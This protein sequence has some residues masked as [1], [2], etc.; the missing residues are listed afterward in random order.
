MKRIMALI[1]VLILLSTACAESYP[2]Y[3]WGDDGASFALLLG[4]DGTILTPVDQYAMIYPITDDGDERALF[5]AA[6]LDEDGEFDSCVLMNDRG[7]ILLDRSFQALEFRRN[8]ILATELSG[9]MTALDADG[10]VLLA[11]GSGWIE[12][13]GEGG[14]LALK[15]GESFDSDAG[16]T[17][18]V[19]A[20]DAEGEETETGVISDFWSHGWYSEG[21]C[22]T[23]DYSNSDG[24]E[25]RYLDADGNI[26]FTV[27]GYADDFEGGHLIL[28]DDQGQYHLLNAS[29]DDA[30]GKAYASLSFDSTLGDRARFIAADDRG[31]IEILN[32]ETLECESTIAPCGTKV[33]S[34]MQPE[35]GLIFV[36]YA[37]RSRIYDLAGKL[38]FEN[39]DYAT[40][41][42]NLTYMVQGDD[43]VS[44]FVRSSGAYPD[45]V[46]TL[47][48]E[49][50]NTLGEGHSYIDGLSSLKG[51]ARYLVTDY[52]VDRSDEP[53]VIDES[54]RYG[55]C[56]ETGKMVIPA[57]Y[58]SIEMLA[59]N[60]YWVNKGEKW[61]MIDESEQWLA[62]VDTDK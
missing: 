24:G 41:E 30:L 37:D 36:W 40:T 59:W 21:L 16:K 32:P 55:V 48:D 45:Q 42:V 49:S 10:N 62:T 13:N 28:F 56:D 57:E 20:V 31:A 23:N 4:A 52:E 33:W 44:R 61:G 35:N 58:D 51:A 46:Q 60:H 18:P 29:G 54:V 3:V 19:V 17:Y 5:C 34:A 50:G 15:T 47:I 27:S 9:C 11:G 53:V 1:A 25:T 2:A 12:P 39:L 26:A 43:S 6:I 14:Y 38:L 22:R 8:T 7:E